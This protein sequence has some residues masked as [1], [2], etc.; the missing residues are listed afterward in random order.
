MQLRN[1]KNNILVKCASDLFILFHDLG[2]CC[3]I[4]K[5]GPSMCKSEKAQN[6]YMT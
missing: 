1:L 2:K 4:H 6:N 3:K 5:T